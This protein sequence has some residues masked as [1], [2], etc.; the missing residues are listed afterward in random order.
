MSHDVILHGISSKTKIR[1]VNFVP[2]PDFLTQKSNLS[3][4]FISAEDCFSVLSDKEKQEFVD[5]KTDIVF[6]AGEHIVKRGLLANNML[7]LTEGLVKLELMND[8][9]PSTIT[10]LPSHSFI[11]IVCCF[12]FKKIDFTAT[13]LTKAKV[14]IIGM[15]VFERYIKNNGDFALNLIKHMSG[16]TNQLLHRLT[17]LSQ[18]HIDGA[19]AFILLD[20]STIYGADAFELPVTRTELANMLDYSKESVINALSKFNKEGILSVNDRKINIL[21]RANLE[22]ICKVG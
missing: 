20:F 22:Q 5:N 13:A 21:D 10:I 16:M 1:I 15:D 14:S 12:A 3:N 18:K 9:K 17:T 7:Y 4:E 8:S 19:L 2:M 6:E 11:G